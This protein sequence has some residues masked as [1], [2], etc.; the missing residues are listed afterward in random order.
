MPSSRGSSRPRDRAQVSV[1]CICRQV[2]V[3][4][5]PVPAFYT[6]FNYL[7]QGIDCSPLCCKQGLV[8]PSWIEQLPLL[9]PNSHPS[10]PQPLPLDNHH[11]FS[12]MLVFQY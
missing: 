8:C 11:L 4:L 12:I 3:P 5:A 9:V 1:S 7:S 6:L 2:P 10:V